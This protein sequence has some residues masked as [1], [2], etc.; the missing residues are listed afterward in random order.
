MR[1]LGGERRLGCVEDVALEIKSE[2]L[3]CCLFPVMRQPFVYSRRS[4]LKSIEL[5]A[6]VLLSAANRVSSF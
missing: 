4:W 1:R 5:R 2:S 6:L 3:R